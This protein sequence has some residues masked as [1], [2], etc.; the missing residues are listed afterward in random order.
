MTVSHD[1]SSTTHGNKFPR[2]LKYV[3]SQKPPPTNQQILVFFE[4][5]RKGTSPNEPFVISQRDACCSLMLPAT[6]VT[7]STQHK[8]VGSSCWQLRQ[9]EPFR[10]IYIRERRYFGESALVRLSQCGPVRRKR[11]QVA[12]TARLHCRP[13]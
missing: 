3:D 8:G 11:I 9:E 2:G 4:Y 1:R 10:I 12:K 7:T 6:P 5:N 13:G